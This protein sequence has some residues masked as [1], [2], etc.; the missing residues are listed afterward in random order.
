AI[1]ANGDPLPSWLSFDANTRT[2]GGTPAQTDVGAIDLRVSAS[3]AAGL[4]VSDLFR[5]TVNNVNDSPTGSVSISGNATKGQVLTASH[6]LVDLDGLGAITYQWQVSADGSNWGD[7]A[8]ASGA[9]FTLSA[10]EIG[11]QVRVEAR[12]T[13][14]GGSAESVASGASAAVNAQIQGDAGNNDLLGTPLPDHLSGLAGDDSLSGQDGDDLLDGGAGNDWLS[15]GVGIDTARY[16]GSMSQYQLSFDQRGYLTVEAAPATGEAGLDTLEGIERLQFADGTV[17]VE[18]A[19]G[20]ELRVNSTTA[21]GQDYPSITGLADGGYVVSW[22]SHQ[23]DGSGWG[24]YAQRYGAD[25]APLGGEVEVNSTT[26]SD[27]TNPTITALADGGYAVS[28]Q[29]F[30]GIYAQ[31]YDA[32]GAAVGGEVLVHSANGHRLEQPMIAA[33]ADGGYVVSWQSAV[34]GDERYDIYLQS[35]FADGTVQGGEVLVYSTTTFLVNGLNPRVAGLADGGYV[36]SWQSPIQDSISY[37][38]YAQRYTANGAVMGGEV[39]VN[40]T[41]ASDQMNPAIAALS[42]GGYLVSWM[43]YDQDGSSGIY[44]QRYGADGQPLA[45]SQQLVGDS[46]NNFI[47]LG[48][49]DDRFAGG[50]GNDTVHAGNGVDTAL[51]QG[52]QRDFILDVHNVS[53]LL[54]A[55]QLSVEGSDTLHD[56]ERV[57]FGD[58]V[59]MR[60]VSEL[61]VNTT[62]G[63]QQPRIAGLVGG[64]Y[65]VAWQSYDQPGSDLNVYMQRYTPEAGLVGGALRVNSTT[66]GNQAEPSV[67]ALVDGGWIVTW[68][69][70]GANGS[71]VD[72]YMQRYMADG[73]AQGNE[74]RVNTN[75]S[76]FQGDPA[77][78]GLPDGGWVLSWESNANGWGVYLQRYSANG[79][80]EGSE[81]SVNNS[82]NANGPGGPSITALSDGG[83][84]LAWISDDGNIY[85]QR[86]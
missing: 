25:G 64:G 58:G 73:S 23:Q 36:V 81:V 61:V 35:Y 21:S 13:D 78:A 30:V 29:S 48:S 34:R 47:Q 65:V 27:Q 72:I 75:T 20:G 38:I 57:E 86:Y 84:L 28:W 85:Q 66:A 77:V 80:P 22:M 2:F 10:A 50:G 39:L 33:L 9:T 12:Y 76:G 11:R 3:D 59:D 68:F 45:A 43:S 18:G 40:S 15:G 46:G 71:D 53:E 63:G 31:R 16:A 52:N 62:S 19:P 44:A 56:V 7:I 55:D 5:L 74:T 51:Y 37:D 82:T 49:S 8:G 79:S 4:M 1:L 69:G 17:A 70:S 42:D 54:I 24:I 14:G 41:T 67:S 60:I 6:A 83:W 32:S 26:A